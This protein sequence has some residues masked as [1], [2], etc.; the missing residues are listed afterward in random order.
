MLPWKSG[1]Q[2]P[3][4]KRTYGEARKRKDHPGTATLDRSLAVVSKQAKYTKEM[5]KSAA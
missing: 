4:I 5:P 1:K 3:Q 2:R